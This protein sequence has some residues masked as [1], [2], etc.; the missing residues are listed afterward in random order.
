[1]AVVASATAMTT[2][3]IRIIRTANGKKNQMLHTL[4]L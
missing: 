4:Q 1:M 2:E 3:K